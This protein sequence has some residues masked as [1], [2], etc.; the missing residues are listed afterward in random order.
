M[1]LSKWQVIKCCT[2]K[3]DLHLNGDSKLVLLPAFVFVF[4][5][6]QTYRRIHEHISRTDDPRKGKSD[7]NSICK[8]TSLE[9]KISFKPIDLSSIPWL[10]VLLPTRAVRFE[11]GSQSSPRRRRSKPSAEIKITIVVLLWSFKNCY[12]ESFFE[13]HVKGLFFLPEKAHR[14]CRGKGFWRWRP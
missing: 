13:Y 5:L 3:P 9:Y 2:G 4:S 7:V 12:F 8:K 1:L 10:P 6:V 14:C 11:Q